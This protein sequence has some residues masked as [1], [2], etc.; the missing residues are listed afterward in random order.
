MYS[1]AHFGYILVVRTVLILIELVKLLFESTKGTFSEI[2]N[3]LGSFEGSFTL[4]S[5]S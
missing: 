4:T 5:L 3:F 2:G 1:V